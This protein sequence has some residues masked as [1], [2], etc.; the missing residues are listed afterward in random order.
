MPTYSIPAKN[1]CGELVPQDPIDEPA[2][3]LLKRIQAERE[4]QETEARPGR[5]STR[6]R[7]KN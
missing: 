5:K 1:F 3:K 2:S 4:K 6:R 7:V